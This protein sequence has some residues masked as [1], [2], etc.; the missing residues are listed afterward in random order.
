MMS[1]KTFRIGQ[2]VKFQ[3]GARSVRGV[4]KEDRGPI[5]REGRVLYLVEFRPESQSPDVSYIEL[6][7][8]KL[9]PLEDTVAF[10]ST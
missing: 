1:M 10:E 4:I 9:N 7:A 3:Y 2:R 5:G 6:P 8:E